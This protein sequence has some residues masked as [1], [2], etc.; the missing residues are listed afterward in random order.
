MCQWIEE[1]HDLLRTVLPN[2]EALCLATILVHGVITRRKLAEVTNLS[3]ADLSKALR[4]LS[5]KELVERE[6][7]IIGMEYFFPK[8]VESIV[9]M[10]EKQK[11]IMEEKIQAMSRIEDVL[12]SREGT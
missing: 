12:A 1:L 6:E 4:G 8:N 11:K 7:T 3:S 5:S 9:K 10:A 2:E